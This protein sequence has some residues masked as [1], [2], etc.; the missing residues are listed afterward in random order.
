VTK[1]LGAVLLAEAIAIGAMLTITADLVA[2]THVEGQGGVNVWG[3]RGTVAHQ[4]RPNEIRIA[5]VG[6]TRAFSWGG[7]ASESLPAALGWM[8]TRTTDRA[9]ERFRPVVGLNLGVLG[10][11][12]S[13]YASTLAHYAYLKPDYICIYDDL[14]RESGVSPRRHSVVFALSGYSPA[15]P[16]VLEEKGMALRYGS[17]RAGYGDGVVQS[18]GPVRRAAGRVLM[19]IGYAARR[20][21]ESLP[22]VP[23]GNYVDGMIAAVETARRL[24]RG[25]IVA[26][27]PAETEQDREHLRTLQ[28]RLAAS[29]ASDRAIRL[30]DLTSAP[31]V[32]DPELLLD[33]YDYGAEGRTRVAA[34]ISPTLLELIDM[35]PSS[36]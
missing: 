25:V 31:D 3:Y 2:H 26:V 9:G 33:G 30:I 16:L 23:A 11:P 1:R 18:Q 29:L 24:A 36:R 4:P 32:H 27:G 10:A 14:G 17:V 21:D 5:V 15:L 20:V 7:A 22:P 6:G 12:S 35:N 19:G 28:S 13:T 34:A 8:V